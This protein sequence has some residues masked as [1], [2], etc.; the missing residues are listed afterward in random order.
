MSDNGK[1]YVIHTYS[2]YENKVKADIEKSIENR[3]MEELFFDIQVPMEEV[4]ETKDGRKKVT[5]K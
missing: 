5:L 4:V 3:N 1:W 2:G